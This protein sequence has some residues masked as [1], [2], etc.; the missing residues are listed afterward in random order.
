[1]KKVNK[2]KEPEFREHCQ[3]CHKITFCFII[4][5]LCRYLPLEN[6]IRQNTVQI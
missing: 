6:E 2:V 3:N 5:K 4:P 1:M